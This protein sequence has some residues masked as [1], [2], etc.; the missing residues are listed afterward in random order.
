MS[1]HSFDLQ[2]GQMVDLIVKRGLREP[3][4]LDALMSVPAT[5]L[6]QR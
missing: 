3:R 1:E 6:C 5:F 4:L 2:R